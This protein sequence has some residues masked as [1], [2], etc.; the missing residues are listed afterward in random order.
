M[1]LIMML[2]RFL[3]APPLFG[4]PKCNSSFH[5]DLS[6]GFCTIFLIICVI[7]DLHDSRAARGM[8]L[9]CG[10]QAGCES[11]S[12]GVARD[13]TGTG[14]AVSGTWACGTESGMVASGCYT[15][16]NVR[17]LCLVRIC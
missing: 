11:L 6:F 2:L 1:R 7:K 17:E 14:T 16:D 4:L 3:F 13:V 5:P 15:Q 8:R 10:T 9:I 12:L